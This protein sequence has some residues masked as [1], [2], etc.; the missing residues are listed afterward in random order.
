[1]VAVLTGILFWPYMLVN[2][3]L[4]YGLTALPLS[5]VDALFGW[6]TG[7]VCAGLILL[8][9]FRGR[10]WRPIMLGWW[11]TPFSCRVHWEVKGPSG[12][13]RGLYND[14]MCPHERIFGQTFGDFVS[15]EKRLNKHCGE[16]N[17]REN[18]ERIWAAGSDLSA[19]KQA[20]EDLGRS[21]YSVERT[22]AHDRYM[23]AFVRNFNA[24]KR[25]R[26]VPVLLKGWGGQMFYW[27]KLPR[28]TGQEP[29]EELVVRYREE[30]FDGSGF[31]VVTDR[32]LK[33]FGPEDF[34]PEAP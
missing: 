11:D 28:F 32:V 22:E 7:L 9:P 17:K 19:L 21:Y 10:L 23:K 1:M 6:Q 12:V 15:D 20:K 29:I 14:F 4:I 18:A 5:S 31:Q 2:G 24:G 13:W 34:E 16:T 26:L 8:F 3:L 27:G 33:Q 30:L 25:K